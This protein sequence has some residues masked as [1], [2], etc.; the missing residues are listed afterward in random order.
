MEIEFADKAL[1]RLEVDPRYHAGLPVAVVRR[2][3]KTLG[4]IRSAHDER[5]FRQMRSL[6]F[7][8]LRGS[9][10][11]QYSMRLNDQFRLIIELEKSGGRA[12]AILIEITDYH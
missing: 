10:S 7:E 5:D 2:Y 8:K 9:R 4:W 11:H 6:N 1:D 12:K 3:R